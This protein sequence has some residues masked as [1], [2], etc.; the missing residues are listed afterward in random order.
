MI[1]E[2]Q[3]GTVNFE[4]DPSKII[5]FFIDKE[6]IF[7][8]SG[9]KVVS[10][11]NFKKGPRK[12]PSPFHTVKIKEVTFCSQK[13][14]PQEL[15]CAGALTLNILASRTVRNKC[16]LFIS[17]SVYGIFCYSSLNEL[18]YLSIHLFCLPV[19]QV[20]SLS[21]T[22]EGLFRLEFNIIHVI[23][24]A[25]PNS[26]VE[27]LI[28]TVMPFGFRPVGSDWVMKMKLS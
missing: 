15:D 26:Y 21:L 13:S 17:H 10:A 4:T 14:L 1:L 27:A 28:P 7:R 23:P 5:R 6:N 19:I 25:L 3:L 22:V 12:L 16:L 18:K 8:A 2:N 24:S 20:L 11:L 9:H